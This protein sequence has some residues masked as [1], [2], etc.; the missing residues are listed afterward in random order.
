MR[1]LYRCP[2]IPR[3][4]SRIARKKQA[5]MKGQCSGLRLDWPGGSTRTWARPP[6][7][8]LQQ[9]TRIKKSVEGGGSGD[10]AT[11][12]KERKKESDVYVMP[13]VTELTVCQPN[14]GSTVQLPLLFIPPVDSLAGI[15]ARARDT[16]TQHLPHPLLP[17]HP[18]LCRSTPTRKSITNPTP[19][20]AALIFLSA[21]RREIYKNTPAR[22]VTK[23]DGCK[24]HG[25]TR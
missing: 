23:E 5:D 3:I 12:Q 15:Y 9:F 7:S 24:I 20:A 21:P 18:T 14:T 1:Q 25:L 10:C 2:T 4:K 22:T 17:I 16:P 8:L 6:F 19:A 11:R 13:R